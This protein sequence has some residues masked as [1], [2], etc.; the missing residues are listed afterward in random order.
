MSTKN[1]KFCNKD[2]LDII[3]SIVSENSCEECQNK[4]S[5]VVSV[6]MCEKCKIRVPKTKNDKYCDECNNGCDYCKLSFQKADPNV[7][8]C[9]R[10]MCSHCDQQYPKTRCINC[11]SWNR[12]PNGLCNV[13]KQTA[14]PIVVNNYYIN[15]CY[16]ACY[17]RINGYESVCRCRYYKEQSDE[18]PIEP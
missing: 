8:G 1:C 14:S 7:N 2:L 15:R 11:Y 3:F 12:E 9:G 6:G 5:G 10:K 4:L 13:C 18:Q 16:G 17:N